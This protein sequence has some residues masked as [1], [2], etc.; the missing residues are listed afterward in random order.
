MAKEPKQLTRYVILFIFFI[1]IV[2]SINPACNKIERDSLWS[3]FRTLSSLNWFSDDCCDWEGITCN[4]AGHV[5]HLLLPFKGL[6]G[7]ILPTSSL[8]NLTHLTHLNLSHN[9]LY[10]SLENTRLLLS[11][12]C[13]EILDLSYNHLSGQ[14]PF[15]LPSGN[16]RTLDLS[17]N[18]F[19][20]AIASSF[21]QQAWNLTSFNVSNNDFSGSIPSS[22]CLH[23]SPFIRVL[24][25]SLNHFNGSIIHGLGKCNKLQV[26]RASHNNLSGLLPE[27]NYNATKLEEIAL[28]TNGL[29]GMLPTSIAKLSKLKLLLLHFNNLEGSLPISLMNCTNLIEIH[30][31]FNNLNGNITMLNF[32]KLSQL[33]KLDLGNNCLT[34]VVPISLYSCKLLKAIR[35]SENDLEGQIQPEILSLKSLSFLPLSTNRLTNM[36]RAMKLFMRCRSLEFLALASAFVDGETRADVG[37]VEFD[38]LQ[39]LQFLDLGYCDLTGEIPK[40]LSKLKRLGVLYMDHNKITGS[41]PSW[42]GTLPM[43]FFIN[44]ESNLISGEFPKELC[45]LPKLLSEQTAGQVDDDEFELRIYGSK[46]TLSVEYKF[47]Y[48]VPAI[49]IGNNTISGNIP[50]E[51]GQLQLLHGLS[52]RKNNF[53]SNI[54]EQIS[55]LENLEALDLSRNQFTGNIPSSFTKLNFLAV[56]NVSYNNLEGSIPRGTQLQSFNASAF[57]G[58]LKLC[59]PPL[60]NEC[61]A[62]DDNDNAG[63]SQDHTEDEHENLISWFH[64]SIILGFIVGFW[65]VC[66]PLVLK[67]KWRYGYFKFLNRAQDFLYV[68]I[69]DCVYGKRRLR[70]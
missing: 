60:P 66:C 5:T 65:G 35:L 25:F 4:M 28:P 49:F 29:S 37:M 56:F 13:L 45:R 42:I 3:S 52:F 16:M 44:L 58:N 34:D 24:D 69:I 67:K 6:K 21:F 20:A 10:G 8:E 54:P 23:S 46:G 36:T 11:L 55:N 31:A 57:E 7:G 27:D 47:S 17:S 48:F 53:S 50:I 22:I 51:I 59:G 38:G 62:N 12:S 18:H 30:L 9:L 14:L 39:N 64:T 63:Y 70:R 19:H 33:T 41:I 15:L 2:I 68:I 26:F 32:S 40:W 1:S 43:L 61:P